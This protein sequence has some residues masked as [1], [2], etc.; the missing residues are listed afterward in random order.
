MRLPVWL[1]VS[2]AILATDEKHDHFGAHPLFTFVGTTAKTLR[3]RS[4]RA[5]KNGMNS[6]MK[7]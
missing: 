2:S 4:I 6:S 5:P 3:V 7:L 1:P